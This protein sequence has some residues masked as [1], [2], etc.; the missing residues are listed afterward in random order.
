MKAKKKIDEMLAEYDELR[1]EMIAEGY[2]DVVKYQRCSKFARV[3]CRVLQMILA[4]GM[5]YLLVYLRLH[6]V[7][8]EQGVFATPVPLIAIWVIAHLA[9]DAALSRRLAISS[10][11]EEALPVSGL[12]ARV[13]LAGGIEGLQAEMKRREEEDMKLGPLMQDFEKI[14]KAA[15]GTLTRHC[16]WVRQ[17]GQKPQMEVREKNSETQ[18]YNVDKEGYERF[19]SDTAL[20]LEIQKVMLAQEAIVQKFREE[21]G[22]E[23]R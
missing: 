6:R 20:A 10:W 18:K 3:L 5:V 15:K 21:L 22:K 13:I 11:Y 19:L 9:F 4:A 2:T 7:S 16:G 17:I 14:M 23:S 8:S 1:E 12:F